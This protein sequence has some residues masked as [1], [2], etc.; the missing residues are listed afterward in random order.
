MSN[1][2]L[3]NPDILSL[4]MSKNYKKDMLLNESIDQT[5]YLITKILIKDSNKDKNHKDHPIKFPLILVFKSN[6]IVYLAQISNLAHILI[7]R[8]KNNIYL[9]S[10]MKFLHA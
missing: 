9:I 3:T 1:L 10:V 5:R 4:V 8:Q 7:K 2:N 6:E